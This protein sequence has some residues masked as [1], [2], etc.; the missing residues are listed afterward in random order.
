[1]N[2]MDG[3]RN[4]SKQEKERLFPL[5]EMHFQKY[6]RDSSTYNPFASSL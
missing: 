4:A 3:F 5:Q 1:L 2:R 6:L